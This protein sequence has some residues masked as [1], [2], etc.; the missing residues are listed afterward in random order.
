[1][2]NVLWQET[3][4]CFDHYSSFLNF[5]L[6]PSSWIW[7]P[8]PMNITPL[9]LDISLYENVFAL[10]LQGAVYYGVA[11]GISYLR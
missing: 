6:I 2:K 5:F 9:P 4:T 11:N 7:A 8:L 1:M 3:I 10:G